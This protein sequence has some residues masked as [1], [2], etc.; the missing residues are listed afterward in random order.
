V[1]TALKNLA[2]SIV[3]AATNLVLIGIAFLGR[4]SHIGCCQLGSPSSVIG[5]VIVP[6]LLLLTFAFLI[7]DVFRRATR[8]Q[9]F[10]A[11]VL[12]IPSAILVFHTKL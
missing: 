9:G 1:H 6:I 2:T 5:M 7:R 3:L 10:I 12:S 11:L 8:L 4:L